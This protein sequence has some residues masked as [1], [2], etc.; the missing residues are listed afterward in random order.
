M[1]ETEPTQTVTQLTQPL[2]APERKPEPKPKVAVRGGK[3]IGAAAMKRKAQAAA[4]PA[5]RPKASQD[6]VAADARIKKLRNL[7]ERCDVGKIGTDSAKAK[8]FVLYKNN[9]TVSEYL[10]AGGKLGWLKRDVKYGH[11]AVTSK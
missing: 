5:A 8:Q 1:S 7:Q 9:Q 10:A 2:A 11:V 6:G 4:K 3:A